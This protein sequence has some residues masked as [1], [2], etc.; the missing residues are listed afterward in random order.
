MIR[1][2]PFHRYDRCGLVFGKIMCLVMA[3]DLLFFWV[4]EFF[5]P[6]RDIDRAPDFKRNRFLQVCLLV[7][8]HDPALVFEVAYRLDL[9]QGVRQPRQTYINS[10]EAGGWKLEAG[11]WKDDG[12]H[13]FASV[14][15]ISAC[16]SHLE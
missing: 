6:E 10:T 2:T 11:S 5:W 3:I 9:L 13:R 7:F 4:L 8:A 15:V 1:M 14:I 12:T 16:S